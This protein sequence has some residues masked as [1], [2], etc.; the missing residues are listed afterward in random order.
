VKESYVRNAPANRE[1]QEVAALPYCF[2]TMWLAVAATGLNHL[3]AEGK[4]CMV[5]LAAWEGWPCSRSPPRERD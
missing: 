3:N 1:L 2:V 5:R 4:S